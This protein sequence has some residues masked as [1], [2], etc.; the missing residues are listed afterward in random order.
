MYLTYFYRVYYA[1]VLCDVM[2]MAHSV[3]YV[4]DEKQ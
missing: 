1:V 4:C 3:W 2:Q